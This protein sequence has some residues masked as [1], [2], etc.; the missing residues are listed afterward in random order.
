MSE[1]PPYSALSYSWDDQSPDYELPCSGALIYITANVKSCLPYLAVENESNYFWI[2]AVCINQAN[3][4]E[5]DHQVSLMKAIYKSASTVI[6]WL[7]ES[8]PFVDLATE[9]LNQNDWSFVNEALNT[10]NTATKMIH[11][12]KGVTHLVTRPWFTRLWTFQEAV[13]ASEVEFRCGRNQLSYHIITGLV[14]KLGDI[15]L[16]A[17][18]KI[19]FWQPGDVD[20]GQVQWERIVRCRKH[21]AKNRELEFPKLMKY[22]RVLLASNPVDKVYGMLGLASPKL[23]SLVPI[24]YGKPYQEVYVDFMRVY[25]TA[26]EDPLILNLTK[27]SVEGLPSWCPNFSCRPRYGS[28]IGISWS[29]EKYSAGFNNSNGVG[30]S[31]SKAHELRLISDTKFPVQN[32][33]VLDKYGNMISLQGFCVDV[34]SK[35]VPFPWSEEDMKRSD[36][37]NKAFYDWEVDCL[38]VFNNIASQPNCSPDAHFR[39]RTLMQGDYKGISSIQE[40]DYQLLMTAHKNMGTEQENNLL[41]RRSIALFYFITDYAF[42]RSYFSTTNGRIG[43]GPADTQPG[44]QVCILYTATTPFILRPISEDPKLY[45]WI[46]ESYVDGIMSGEAFDLKESDQHQ[47]FNVI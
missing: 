10:R 12:R 6:I 32:S 19:G 31:Q 40:S 33:A 13:L 18:I 4:L 11:F 36:P 46:G 47:V 1:A 14:R 27:V 26:E 15:A 22:S 38:E 35:S 25:L 28:S 2:D 37:P 20:R 21:L 8:N 34:I 17:F 29:G 5:K 16:E 23:Q 9:L 45:Q 42:G 39:T 44:D 41:S 43:L 24:E 7:G 3:I 30:C